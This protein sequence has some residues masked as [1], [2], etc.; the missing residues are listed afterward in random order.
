MAKS[1]GVDSTADTAGIAHQD[2]G[3]TGMVTRKNR[4]GVGSLKEAG[5][6]GAHRNGSPTPLRT[7]QACSLAVAL[8]WPVVPLV[9]GLW[10]LREEDFVQA[11]QDRE[12]VG[13]QAPRGPSPPH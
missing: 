11:V 13:M 6:H 5:V 4:L 1:L 7:W 10:L 9:V 12:A 2:G 8:G 3:G